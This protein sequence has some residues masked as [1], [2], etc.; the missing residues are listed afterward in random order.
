MGLSA[1]RSSGRLVVSTGR[2]EGIGLL[3]QAA[4]GT[5]GKRHPGGGMGASVD[6]TAPLKAKVQS[7]THTTTAEP[8]TSCGVYAARSYEREAPPSH[9]TTSP[10]PPSLH[11]DEGPE[12]QPMPQPTAPPHPGLESWAGVDAHVGRIRFLCLRDWLDARGKFDPFAFLHYLKN[13]G[14]GEVR[15]SLKGRPSGV[16]DNGTTFEEVLLNDIP[17]TNSTTASGSLLAELLGP[18]L[19]ALLDPNQLKATQAKT[20]CPSWDGEG[21]TARDY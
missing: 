6:T 10:T 19:A 4:R 3:V 16:L 12:S 8:G 9:T 2:A 15:V 1:D 14:N 7:A 18:Q 11:G 21:A 20:H 13:V 17:S 5:T